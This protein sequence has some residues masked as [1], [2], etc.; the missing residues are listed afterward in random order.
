MGT[1][2]YSICNNKIKPCYVF[3]N[4]TD[5]SNIFIYRVW[6]CISYRTE[7]KLFYFLF[8]YFKDIAPLHALYPSVWSCIRKKV[9]RSGRVLECKFEDIGSRP[10]DITFQTIHFWRRSSTFEKFCRKSSIF[11]VKFPTGMSE[12]FFD[13]CVN[14]SCVTRCG[15]Q[16]L[17]Q[18]FLQWAVA[19]SYMTN[20]LLI[21]GEIFAHFLIY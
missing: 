9:G 15:C 13:T 1:L 2:Q 10:G 7:N 20:G 19:K 16:L 12:S 18:L 21:Y 3:T 8:I 6:Y 14:W 4:M 17:R 5:D 11:I